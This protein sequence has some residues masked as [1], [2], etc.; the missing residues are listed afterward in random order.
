MESL[1]WSQ[2]TRLPVRFPSSWATVTAH[3]N[4]P[5]TILPARFPNT[6]WPRISMGTANSIWQSLNSNST[7]SIFLGKGDGTF[8]SKVDY[9]AGVSV[10]GLTIGDYNGDGVP[11]L[12]V[13]DSLCSSS[14]CPANG[15]VNV[16]LGN[17]DGT[18][19][20]HLDFADRWTACDPSQPAISNIPANKVRSD[21][22]DSPRRTSSKIPCRSSRRSP[23]DPSARFQRFLRFLRPQPW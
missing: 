10:N 5:W 15:S 11:D 18:F 4:L 9:P 17:G 1:I 14:P 3:F 8:Q 21:A 6:S 13:S 7:I 20:S 12:A 16:L 2:R 19:Q 22:P 23:R